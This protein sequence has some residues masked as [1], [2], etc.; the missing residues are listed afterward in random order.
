[1]IAI[2]DS[3][4]GFHPRWINY[5]ESNGISYRLVNCYSS[6]LI[7]DL[8]GCRVL[9]WHHAQSDPRDILIAR[10]ILFALEHAGLHVFPDFRTAWHFDDKVGQKYLLEAL[11]IEAMPAHVFT[12]RQAALDWANTAEFP[13]VFKLRRGAGSAGVQLVRNK[14]Q[15][16]KLIRRA[17]GRGFPVYD[18]WGSLKDRYLKFR[19]GLT[20]IKDVFKGLARLLYRPRFS[21]ILGS[22]K[23][24]VY[25]Q[26][27][28]SANDSDTRVVVIGSRAFAIQRHVRPGDFRASGSGLID[29][30]PSNIDQRC[31]EL[32]FS[33]ARKLG[34]TCIC[35]DFVL[36][37]ESL[38]KVIEISYGF[39]QTGYE[40]CP[41][42]WTSDFRYHPGR[43]DPQGWMVEQ[44][45]EK[46]M[47]AKP[48][49][50]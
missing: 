31:I 11:T 14:G 23:G 38:P 45:L 8:D 9:L 28:A 26:D 47:S 43:F 39:S 1:M 20:G 36:D 13:K 24:Y 5:C 40:A 44:I 2:H 35:F 50:S 29:H 6:R 33:A 32:A 15:A 42:F 37:A 18:P 22:E 10:Q 21:R 7:S 16:Q 17:F 48:M 46:A 30:D 49:S 4:S 41:G 3:P 25:F 12:E 19:L 34:G 27:F